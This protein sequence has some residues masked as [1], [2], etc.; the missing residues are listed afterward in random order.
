MSAQEYEFI[1]Y[2]VPA[3]NVVSLTLDRPEVANALHY[4]LVNELIDA[5]QC[6]D[7]DPDVHVWL[8]KG[9]PRK[10]GRPCFSAGADLKAAAAGV[11]PSRGAEL[12]DLI[13]DLLTPSIAVIDGVCTTGGLELALACDL[14]FAAHTAAFSD[15][16]MKR[17][18]L[19]MG[20]WGG[21]TRL[22]R[23][24]GADKAKEL[25]LL[26]PVS[27]GAEAGQMGLVNRVLA[28]SELDAAA[29][30]AAAHIAGLHRDGVRTTMGF[31]AMQGDLSKR[32]A[33]RWAS[34]ARGFPSYG[35]RPRAEAGAEWVG[36]GQT[37]SAI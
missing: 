18:G 11:P 16:H 2:E 24:V 29:L 22:S 15:L 10:D 33:L 35:G 36:K 31:F 32:D 25:L 1:R 27:T 9:S 14:R 21:A 23:L 30:D 8:L 34:L 37:T 6:L 5:V 19:G 7:A 12:V 13:D 17:F 4:G 3:P 20:G 26:S 28:S